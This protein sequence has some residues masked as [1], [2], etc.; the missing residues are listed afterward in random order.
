MIRVSILYPRSEGTTFDIDYYVSKHMPLVQKELGDTLKGYGV[1]E[2]IGGDHPAPYHC[3]GYLM[4]DSVD[5]FFGGMAGA[6]ET[7]N[8]VANFTDCTPQLQISEVRV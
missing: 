1:D 7:R 3:V 4:F 5:D 6:T 2:G 8:D